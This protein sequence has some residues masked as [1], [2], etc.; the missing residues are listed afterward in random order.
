MIKVLGKPIPPFE[1]REENL[2]LMEAAE[3]RFRQASE[4][5]QML[6]ILAG[7]LS[8]IAGGTDAYREETARHVM[9]DTYGPKFA[10]RVLDDPELRKKIGLNPLE[11]AKDESVRATTVAAND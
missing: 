2:K 11:G 8:Y 4:E 6:S 5:D 7:Q 9:T 3:Q 10:E 1:D